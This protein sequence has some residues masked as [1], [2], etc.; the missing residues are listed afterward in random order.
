MQSQKKMARRRGKTR[1]GTARNHATG[2]YM[3]DMP[4]I[5]TPGGGDS[6]AGGCK[7][8]KQSDENDR[9]RLAMLALSRDRL[10]PIAEKY[11]KKYINAWPFPH[12]VFDGLLPSSLVGKMMDDIPMLASPTAGWE[13]ST[14]SLTD[15]TSHQKLFNQN[16]DTWSPDTRLASMLLKSQPFLAFLRELTGID[17]LIADSQNWS[18]GLM[19]IRRGGYLD[20]HADFTRLSSRGLDRRLNVL[21]YLNDNWEEEGGGDLQLWGTNLT[22]GARIPPFA[23]RMVVFSTTSFSYHDHPIPLDSPAGCSL[24]T[25]TPTAAQQTNWWVTPAAR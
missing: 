22:C 2:Q 15:P 6:A 14:S 19:Q 5:Y 24:C 18:S 9:T 23:N 7:G 12:A 8:D 17:G 1:K 21:L 25:T 16:E 11:H 3:A 20:V 13:A 4:C 10:Q